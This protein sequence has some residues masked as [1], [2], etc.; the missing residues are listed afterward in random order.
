[1]ATQQEL[2]L[3]AQ[4]LSPAAAAELE[5]QRRAEQG[6]AVA[7]ARN[8]LLAE[9][10][11]TAGMFS[12]AVGN[13]AGT[14]MRSAQE[15]QSA[16]LREIAQAAPGAT[17]QE[18]WQNALP[19][20]AKMDPV[21][22]MQLAPQIRALGPQREYKDIRLGYRTVKSKNQF[23]LPEEKVVADTRTGVFE[24]GQL[25]GYLGENNQI[26]PIGNAPSQQQQFIPGITDTVDGAA[27]RA[28]ARAQAG[29][30][31]TTTT[32]DTTI[33]VGAGEFLP[34]GALTQGAMG[35]TQ[36]TPEQAQ[37]LAARMQ[38]AGRQPRG[39]ESS[40]TMARPQVVE[41]RQPM[42]RTQVRGT[43]TS[44]FESMPDSAIIGRW[45][46]LQ[47]KPTLTA[48]EQEEVRQIAAQIGDRGLEGLLREGQ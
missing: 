14:D 45:R 31:S 43:P 3:L 46:A 33:K 18:K 5:R 29:Q 12:Q 34:R 8:P 32:Q 44:R 7:N 1:M 13:I 38:G 22:A 42:P 11:R 35:Q 47:K 17:I 30:G 25:I 20:I 6:L 19:E 9:A 28:A 37:A 26:V 10:A 4:L 21:L 48:S 23:G 24:N 41:Q 39:P 16:Q 15:R 27:N 40:P 36:L 2:G